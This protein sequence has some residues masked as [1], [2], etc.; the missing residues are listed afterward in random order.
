[1]TKKLSIT[2][3]KIVKEKAKDYANKS[4]ESLSNIIENHLE[5]LINENINLR[6]LSPKLKKIVGAVKLPNNFNEKKE[7]ETRLYKL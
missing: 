4:G 3:T 2:I 7:L 5:W 6:T 1:M